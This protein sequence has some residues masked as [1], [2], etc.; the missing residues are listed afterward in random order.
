MNEMFVASQNLKI[1][2]VVEVSGNSLRIELDDDINELT[3]SI[4]GQIYPVGQMGSVIKI[5]FGRKV[6]FAFVRLLRMRSEIIDDEGNI[7]LNANDD[8]RILE[9]DLFGQGVWSKLSEKLDFTRGVE[10]YPLPLQYAYLCLNEELESVYKAAE[11]YAE[12]KSVSPMIPI[13]NYVGGNNAICRANID[14]LFSHHFAILG[15]TGAGKSGTVASILHSVLDH[16]VDNNSLKPRIIM[17]DPHGE[18]PSAFGERATVY[19]AYNDAAMN[20]SEGDLLKLPYWLMSSDELRSLIIG[21]TEFEATSQNNIVYEAITYARQLEAGLL[22]DL[23]ADPDGGA[24]AKTA[25]GITDEDLLKF[26]RDKP[27]PFKLEQFEKHI[28][29]VQGRKLGKKDNL[30]ASSGRDKVDSILKKLKILQANPQLNF[31]MEEFSDDS[32]V[33]K[34]ILSQFIGDAKGKDIRIIDI[35]GLPNEVAG[36]LTAII[37]RLLFQYKLWETKEERE[38]DPILFICEEAHRYVPNHGEA[39]YKE[40]QAAIRRIAKEGRKYGLGLGLISQ[41]PSDVESTV[42]SQCNSWIVLRLTN[43]NDQVHVAKFLPDSL[44]GLTKML[45]AL[46]RREAIFVGEAAAL[47]SRIR[48]NKLS[49]DKLPNSNDISFAKGWVNEP[50]NESKLNAIVKRW[51]N[52]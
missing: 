33:L 30:A 7:P 19:R 32:P 20:D 29:K 34:E 26:D 4:D 25:D 16:R 37:A 49:I 44:S 9:A 48:I 43:S 11:S 14:K 17:I 47:P 52:S 8:A 35:S 36:P 45:P 18:Y 51:S 24:K 12:E 38:Q 28:D 23:G 13:G 5:H 39:Q 6:L 46:T 15:S 31:M 27:V 10:T 22:I 21:K 50:M 3:R 1:G 41:R 42:L 40:A 2:R